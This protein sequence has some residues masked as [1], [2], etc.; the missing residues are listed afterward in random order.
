MRAQVQHY[1]TQASY[2]AY[3]CS[4]GWAGTTRAAP[5]ANAQ[6]Q[7]AL[8]L[9]MNANLILQH[10]SLWS[11]GRPK[12]GEERGG[13]MRAYKG[14]HGSPLPPQTLTIC[15]GPRTLCRPRCPDPLA[16]RSPGLLPTTLHAKITD[17]QPPEQR[18]LLVS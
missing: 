10:N 7:S 11:D 13:N 15:C 12:W 1:V 4:E 6:S 9:L 2:S 17:V 18:L 5:K 14:S 16:P 3:G 8:P